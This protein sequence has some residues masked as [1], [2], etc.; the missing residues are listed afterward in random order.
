M[1]QRQYTVFAVREGSEGCVGG[2]WWREE[3]REGTGVLVATREERHNNRA[4][5]RHS[6]S[7]STSTD[8][9]ADTDIATVTQPQPQ[10]STTQHNNAHHTPTHTQHTHTADTLTMWQEVDSTRVEELV[11]A[12]EG[13]GKGVGG[14][15][16]WGIGGWLDGHRLLLICRQQRSRETKRQRQQHTVEHADTLAQQP[17]TRALSLSPTLCFSSS[18]SITLALSRSLSSPLPLTHTPTHTRTHAPSKNGLGTAPTSPSSSIATSTSSTTL[19]SAAFTLAAPWR[20]SRAVSSAPT[21]SLPC[22]RQA[23]VAASKARVAS[24][25]AP[26]PRTRLRQV[27][28]SQSRT[29][30]VEPRSNCCRA[31]NRPGI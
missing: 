20:H 15:R 26:E 10:H 27:V 8:T 9:A 3:G 2:W 12:E 28:L 1:G 31:W 23:V 19:P 29:R 24:G 30:G 17:H 13:D 11:E 25:S 6:H 5:D 4:P 18:L 14:G 7:H 21:S 22:L 16:R